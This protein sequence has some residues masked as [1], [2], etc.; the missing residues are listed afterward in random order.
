M[1]LRIPFFKFVFAYLLPCLIM[2]KIPTMH[3]ENKNS[4]KILSGPVCS[5]NTG[6]LKIYW[7]VA[8]AKIF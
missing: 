7:N 6:S 5:E 4:K 2:G 1:N 3:F 8:R